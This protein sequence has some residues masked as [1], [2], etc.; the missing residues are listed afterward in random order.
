MRTNLLVALV[1][2]CLAACSGG[3][4]VKG[5]PFTGDPA[6]ASY[7]L[8]GNSV[9]LASG[10]FEEKTGTGVDDLIATDLTGAQLDADFDDDGVTDR[11]VVITRDDGPLKVH[12]LAVVLAGGPSNT[13]ALGKNVLVQKLSLDPKGN[14]IVVDLLSR[15][16]GVPA[17]AAP[18]LE[19]KRRYA[20]KDGKLV[21]VTPA[22]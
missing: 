2:T 7:E 22:K 18:T 16:D 6:N 17:D 15:D 21:D 14:G 12:Y 19:V 1:A 11:A 3:G 10:A 20:V 9:T 8:D 5:G 13:L 4:A